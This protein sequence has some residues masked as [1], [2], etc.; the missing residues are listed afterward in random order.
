[1]VRGQSGA[2]TEWY[3]PRTSFSYSCIT[4]K[5]NLW[6][7]SFRW[8]SGTVVQ[9]A[10]YT[11]QSPKLNPIRINATTYRVLGFIQQKRTRDVGNMNP[12]RTGNP[13]KSSITTAAVTLATT[14]CQTT[15][16]VR[17]VRFL[18]AYPT[19]LLKQQRA[20]L[21]VNFDVVSVSIF[22]LGHGTLLQVHIVQWESSKLSIT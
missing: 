15:S 18:C 2:W 16:A 7:T 3:V 17:D 4:C 5:L 1:M 6:S 8:N 11:I 12:P 21:P 10:S 9:S 22:L 14:T 13:K 20:L 19:L